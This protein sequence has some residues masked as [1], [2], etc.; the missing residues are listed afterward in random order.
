M[1]FFIIHFVYM[2][3][4]IKIEELTS[5]I[6]ITLKKLYIGAWKGYLR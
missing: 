3:K 4:Q 5:S 2:G 6:S 1:I